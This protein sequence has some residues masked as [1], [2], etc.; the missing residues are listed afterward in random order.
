MIKFEQQNYT[1]SYANFFLNL[2]TYSLGLSNQDNNK[3]Q[4]I[5]RLQMEETAAG[6]GKYLCLVMRDIRECKIEQVEIM[7]FLL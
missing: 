4:E 2:T 3:F 5:L 6:L 1:K 7:Y